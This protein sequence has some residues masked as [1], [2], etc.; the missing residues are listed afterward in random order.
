MVTVVLI[1]VFIENLFYGVLRKL[2][3]IS[4]TSYILLRN[5]FPAIISYDRFRKTS[6]LN[7]SAEQGYVISNFSSTVG[8]STPSVPITIS[9]S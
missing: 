4:S 6:K 7:S 5:L 2:D 3:F 1:V 9:R 8:C